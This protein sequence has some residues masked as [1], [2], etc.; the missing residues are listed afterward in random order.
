MTVKNRI[1]MTAAEFSLGE[2]SGKV[3]QR[4][5]DYYEERAKGG[6]GLII[7]GICRVNDMAGAATYSQLAMSHDYHIE[8]MR[9]MADR[10][11]KYGA[12][13][14]IQL[15]HAGRQGQASAINSLP[16]VIPIAKYVPK[17]TDL[18]FKCTP[19]LLGMEEKGYC[20]SVQAPS[21]YPLA[22]HA[23]TRMHAMSKREI[24]NLI[25]DFIDAAERCKKAGVDAVEL[26]GA[27][28][29]LIQ[30]FLSPY[31]NHRGDEY[32]GSLEN[33]MRFLEE[34]I[35]GIR[36]RCGRDY[37]LM[38][39]LSVDEMFA[40]Y[41]KP[42]TG[43]DINT[44]KRIA[45][46]LEELGV[47]AINVSC[48][49]YDTYN[50]WLEPSTY[51]PGWRKYLAK[52][53]KETVNIPVIAVNV[54][55]TP[56]QAEQQLQE[57]YQDFVA[58]ARAFICD[59]HWPEKAQSGHPEDIQRC[60]GCLNCI[61]TFM[62]NAGEGK[63]GECALNMSIANER[64]YYN[65]PKDG[66]GRKV[67]VIGAG[68]SGLTA[69]KT[70]A[71][72]G[73]D[74]E[75]YEKADKA[76]GQVI[77]ASSGS[78]KERLYWAIE[79]LLTAAKKEGAK[80]FLRTELTAD[81]IQ[82]KEPYAVI[83][84]TGGIPV[85]PRSIPGTD[86]ENVIAAPDLLL[87][88]ASIEN[89]T[90]VVI[91]SGMT[92]LETTEFL[93]EH[94]NKVTVVEM[95][96]EIAPGAWFQLIDDEM[97]R[98]KPYG[99][100]FLVGTKLC[101][102]ED[103]GAVVEEIASGEQKKLPADY[104]VLAMGVRPANALAKELQER[105]MQ[106]VY[107]VGDAEKS[108]TIAHACHSAYDT[109]MEIGKGGPAPKIGA[110]P[111]K[112]AAPANAAKAAVAG[113]VAAAGKTIKSVKQNVSSTV[114]K[115]EAQ[116]MG[117]TTKLSELI[118]RKE[119]N[120]LTGKTIV[121]TG[122]SS[123]IGKEVLDKLADPA[124]GNRVLATSRTIEKLTGYGDNVTLFNCDVST[125]EGVD[126]LFEKAES[127]FDK[128][129]IV[130]ANAGAPYYEKFDYVNWNR[131]ENIFNL[132]TISPIYTYTKYLEHLKGREGHLAFTIS[133]MGEMAIP[134]YALY[135][136]TKFAMKGFQ[137]AIRLEA[138]KNLKLT[139]VYPVSTATNFFNVGGN[140]IDVGKPFPVQKAELV[141]DRM[142]SGIEKA[143]KH[144]YPCRIWKP[145]KLL[146][147]VVPQVK[148]FY[149]GMEKNRLKR[150]LEKKA[151]LE[152]KIADKL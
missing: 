68:P 92:G 67:L 2:P 96:D 28:G 136:A 72:R 100:E 142:I 75:L 15:H 6:V 82:A 85:R 109:V 76:G 47:D 98:I 146:M 78:H 107:C 12:K 130:I 21:D 13:L 86:R 56:E 112:A 11:H 119:L 64:A 125:Q 99:T 80:V 70:M 83:T 23:S 143:K 106:N 14:A 121:I 73:F 77:A 38:V 95:A 61:R 20:F 117:S 128:I 91:G 71:M 97:S 22:P 152:Q 138:P 127:L 52:A 79:D 3:T 81:E 94:G 103:G 110:A 129:D 55:R 134:G 116:A 93:N 108:G 19:V 8:P 122:A 88:N 42:G 140:G 27:H 150:F 124:K 58:S 18:V 101:S 118:F 31:T 50:C 149:W 26:H 69:A 35:T 16:V 104:V 37:P 53:I 145:S 120:S 54:I 111:V 148:S 62:H 137:E 65:M 133:A 89:S 32:G 1:V 90:V 151:E 44:G 30:Q 139:A 115:K 49:T 59:P 5:S 40:H 25:Q 102:I 74:V 7:P 63:P 141:A 41:G 29:Y 60:I 147:S 48:A 45:K 33:R 131:I 132:N 34:I 36:E 46:R 51:E 10:L 17:F 105:G 84:A 87:G 123:G 114:H 9:Q 66:Q 43:Y 39:R 113:R 4:L 144:V 24:K 135:T 57:G 126:K